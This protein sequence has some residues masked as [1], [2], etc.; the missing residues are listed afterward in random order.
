MLLGVMLLLRAIDT[1]DRIRRHADLQ[2]LS[3]FQYEDF[4]ACPASVDGYF[5]W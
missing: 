5:G 3:W 1:G 4:V 2:V